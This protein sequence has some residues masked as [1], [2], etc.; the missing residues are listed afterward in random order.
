MHME[1]A[2]PLEPDEH[3]S[4]LVA[5]R[6]RRGLSREDAADRAGLSTEQAEWLEDG[7]LYRFPTGDDAVLAALLYASALGIDRREARRMAG[8]RVPPRPLDWNASGRLTAA[9]LAIVLLGVLCVVLAAPKLG[10]GHGGTATGGG[11]AARKHGPAL[12]PP[13]KISVDVLNG[14]GDINNTRDVANQIGALGYRITRVGRADRFD[15]R[16]TV[17]FAPPGGIAIATRLADRLGAQVQ[18][19][20]GGTNPR[21]VVVTV[22]PKHF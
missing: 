22:G 18:P 4:A 5:A 20:P 14:S 12:P 16:Q 1:L 10:F 8:L 17:V 9:L 13:W 19:L 6:V 3:H 7:R 15:Y 11:A 2:E 21:H